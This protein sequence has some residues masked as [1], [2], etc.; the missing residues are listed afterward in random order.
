MKLTNTGER[1]RFIS[2]LCYDCTCDV[3]EYEYSRNQDTSA[4]EK[5]LTKVSEGIPCRISYER[6]GN[7]AE[8]EDVNSLN[9]GIKLFWDGSRAD[10]KAGSVIHVFKKGQEMV[11][12][13]AGGSALYGS[14]SEIRLIPFNGN[15]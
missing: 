10:I 13:S 7:S 15:A 8:K 9:V 12:K 5:T 3:Y 6:F 1:F 14:H 4:E 2:A 11:F